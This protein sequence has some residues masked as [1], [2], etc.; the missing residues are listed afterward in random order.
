MQAQNILPGAK[1]VIVTGNVASGKTHLLDEL[2]FWKKL[3][4]LNDVVLAK[5][6]SDDERGEEIKK[7]VIDIPSEMQLDIFCKHREEL[8]E[9][10]YLPALLSGKSMVV[11]R[12]FICTFVYHILMTHLLYDKNVKDH[13]W[14]HAGNFC[15]QIVSTVAE[16]H[17]VL[18]DRHPSNENL[19]MPDD[20][21][22]EETF[23]HKEF[24]ERRRQAF[25]DALRIVK[26]RFPFIQVSIFSQEMF[27][28]KST[29]PTVA[30]YHIA[31]QIL[32]QRVFL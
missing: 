21:S 25:I 13:F 14:A 29:A 31:T 20:V 17:I 22:T 26:E 28:H 8:L 6:P 12:G 7:S 19:F 9:E 5:E 24:A 4:K 3:G 1:F 11:E 23:E 15:K 2:R 10:K 18:I 27:S 16:I 30:A 32:C